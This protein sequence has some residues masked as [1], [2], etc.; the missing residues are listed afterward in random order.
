[1]FMFM[2]ISVVGDDDDA[3]ILNC[4]K[5]D[6]DKAKSSSYPAF[7]PH[8]QASPNMD[9]SRM[10]PSHTFGWAYQFGEMPFYKNCWIPT[11][12]NLFLYLLSLY[13]KNP[14]DCVQLYYLCSLFPCDMVLFMTGYLQH[15]RDWY[16]IQCCSSLPPIAE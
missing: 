7:L 10:C 8:G 2:F 13:F 5:G 4:S 3:T 1:M 12:P 15:R 14:S 6:N 16:V 9:S 11:V